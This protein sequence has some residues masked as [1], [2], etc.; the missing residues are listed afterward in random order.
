M[1]DERPIGTGV[2]IEFYSVGP[3]LAGLPERLE[4]ILRGVAGGSSMGEDAGRGLCHDLDI[5]Q[6]VEF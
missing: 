6:L 4:R 5:T 2:D 3:P 1:D